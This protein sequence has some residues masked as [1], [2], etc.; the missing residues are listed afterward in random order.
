MRP[1][2]LA[3]IVSSPLERC[4][5]TAERLVAGRDTNLEIDDRFGEV[6]YGDWTGQEIRRL[7]RDPLWKVVQAQPSAVTFPN[8]EALRQVQD[9]ALAAIRDWNERLGA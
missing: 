5:D 2:P 1:V 7:V 6:R 3:A 8:G 9:R 4:L